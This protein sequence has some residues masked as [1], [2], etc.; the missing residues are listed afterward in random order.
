MKNRKTRIALLFTLCLLIASLVT[1]LIASAVGAEDADFV[2]VVYADGTEQTYTLGEEIVPI[3]V[4]KDFAKCD[5]TGNAYVYTVSAGAAWSFTVDGKALTDMAVTSDMLGKT[6]KADIA[7]TMG[8]EKLCFAVR[9]SIVDETVP[10]DM[11]GEFTVYGYD[12][13]SLVNYLSL[14]NYG[15]E[16]FVA[17]HDEPRY[18]YLRQIDNVFRITLYEDIS[19]SQFDPRWGSNKAT[20]KLPNKDGS[21]MVMCQD[22]TF[23][24][25]Y[26]SDGSPICSG[27]SAS[28]YFD[29]H[30]HTLEI[31]ASESFHFGAMACTPYSM[32]LWF[33][34]TVPG[35]VFSGAKSEAVFYS[36]DDSTVYVGELDGETVKYGQNLSVYGKKIAHVNYGGGVYLWGGRYYQAGA[37]PDFIN[38]SHRLYEAKNCEFYL[39]DQSEAVLFF[40]KDQITNW[41]LEN[42]ANNASNL[43]FENCVFYVN[44]YG[45]KLLREVKTQVDSTGAETPPEE[46]ATKYP[47]RFVDCEFYGIPVQQSGCYLTLSYTGDTAYSVGTSENYGT[48]SEPLYISYLKN[49]TKTRELIDEFGDPF[50]VSADCA[51]RPASEVACVQYLDQTSYWESGVTPFVQDRVVSDGSERYVESG[52]MYLGLPETLAAGQTY[53]AKGIYYAKRVPFAFV[54]T[55]KNGFEGYGLL[56][57]DAVETGKSFASTF[58]SLSDGTIT[59]LTDIVLTQNVD[60]GTKGKVYLDL[61]GRCITVAENASINGAVHRVGDGM[62]LTIYSS[63]EGAVY[64]NR[65]GAPIFS[66]AHGGR[67][68]KICVGD[69]ETKDGTLH[70]GSNVTYISMGSFFRGYPQAENA[71]ENAEFVSKN[72]VFIYKGTGAAFVC[73]NIVTLE[74]TKIAFM[75][76]A[77]GAKPVAI[78]TAA[79]ASASVSCGTCSF[80]APKGVNATTYT[81]LTAAGQVTNSAQ[82]E[83][84]VHFGNC[85]FYGVAAEKNVAI[86]NATVTFGAVGFSSIKDLTAFYGTSVPTGQIT[87]R[88]S[89]QFYIDGKLVYLPLWMYARQADTANVTFDSGAAN[90]GSFEEVWVRDTTACHENFIVDDIFV[91]SYGRRTVAASNNRLTAACLGLASGAMR[92]NISFTSQMKLNFWIPMDSPMTAITVGGKT[93]SIVT[94]LDYADNYYIIQTV[95]T[96]SMLRSDIPIVVQTP[97]RSETVKVSLT[98][99]ISGLLADPK[100]SDEEKALLYSLVSYSETVIDKDL[101][102]VAPQ[103][104]VDRAVQ[105]GEETVFTGALTGASFDYQNGLVLQVNGIGN[106]TV[107]LETASGLHREVSI[108]NGIASFTD[109]PLWAMTGEFTLTCGGDVYTYSLA[110]YKAGVSVA[111]RGYA[112]ALYTVAY[113]ADKWN[114]AAVKGE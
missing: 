70:S 60:F 14:S 42:S 4:P 34:S 104:Y 79:E 57:A 31:G 96:P 59:L 55:M 110:A 32:R 2:T 94:T 43:K 28:V 98:S 41:R 56:G 71:T 7:G 35:A 45:T 75:P 61:N 18:R 58:G 105:I 33:Y 11:R 38:I 106:A 6:V 12:A 86:V 88:S 100:V 109:L 30:G 15:D 67:A 77:A 90:L 108:K 101:G 99:Y 87:A 114:A 53:A 66:L 46:Q 80:Y 72:G 1:V 85:A 51:L 36:D 27:T 3:P 68:G 29:L 48:A 112:D 20:W 49:P 21:A 103:G 81:C 50:T 13:E 37:N 8:T 92:V 74:H 54:Y 22:R 73:A 91:Y 89:A 102:L 113:Y 9:E 76:D 107:V 17:T 84:T 10:E 69:Y 39:A 19:V 44:Q 78:A 26:N 95:L 23:R 97:Q 16:E 62:T 52:G 40:E 64:E 24:G 111:Q 63:R 65:S 82:K 47:L 93:T 83:Q 5:S 25:E